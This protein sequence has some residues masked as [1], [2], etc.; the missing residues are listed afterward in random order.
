MTE[1]WQPIAERKQEERFAR[2]PQ[3]WHLRSP[4][5]EKRLNV[6]HVPRESGILSSEELRL[7][8]TFDATALVSRLV[9]WFIEKRRCRY[10]LLQTRRPSRSKRRIA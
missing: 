5:D 1:S 2:I 3:D 9:D 4:I 8:E 10:C 7:T 6:L